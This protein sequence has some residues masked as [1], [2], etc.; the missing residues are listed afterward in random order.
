[1]PKGHTDTV[2]FIDKYTIPSDTV[3]VPYHLQ[4]YTDGS[5]I[6]GAHSAIGVFFGAGHPLNAGVALRGI[7]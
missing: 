5:V 4:V 7:R 3:I 1:M 2:I 6:P